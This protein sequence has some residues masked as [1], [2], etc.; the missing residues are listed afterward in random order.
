MKRF[1]TS[2]KGLAMPLAVMLIFVVALLGTALYAYATTDF[3]HFTYNRD[4]KKAEYL[5]RTGVEVT[6]KAWEAVTFNT[7]VPRETLPVYMMKDGT[8]VTPDEGEDPPDDYAGYYTVTVNPNDTKDYQGKEIRV[9]TFDATAVV[10]KATATASAY[11]VLS[12]DAYA[13]GWYTSGGTPV[14]TGMTEMDSKVVHSSY[15]WST[16]SPI[17]GHAFPGSIRFV[18]PNPSNPVTFT[19]N[20]N[21]KIAYAGKSIYF[22][23]PISL[24]NGTRT[25][26]V[27]VLS[28]GDIVINGDVELYAYYGLLGSG[29]GTLVLSVLEDYEHDDP[30]TTLDNQDGIQCGKVYF[31]GDVYITVT[32]FFSS[33][34]T[35]IF[36]RGDVYYFMNASNV[37]NGVDLVKY[38]IDN[39]GTGSFISNIISSL[40]PQ[41]QGKY[42]KS[43][44]RRIDPVLNNKDLPEHLIPP[45]PDEEGTVIWQ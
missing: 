26:N 34:R 39:N 31:N 29:V 40:Y 38:Y 11:T 2:R 25:K 4:K 35:K 12:L 44:M 9:V 10:G 28:G 3:L 43:C 23:M 1:V 37:D 42:D 22:D 13:Q 8:F 15:W 6:I 7:N 24:R 33:S 5:A 30:S 18:Q 36:S 21:Q 41:A 27:L 14:E 45:H 20:P 19:L 17:K 32:N 16:E